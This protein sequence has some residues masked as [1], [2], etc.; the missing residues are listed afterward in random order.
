MA[1]VGRDDNRVTTLAALS[2]SDGTTTVPLW[3]DP[4]THRLLTEFSADLGDLT[5]VTIT[6]AAAG[7]ILY[8]NSANDAWIN[9]A[10]GSN[11]EVLTLASG[12][13]SWAAAGAGDVTAAS[14]FGTDNV[15]I[16]SDGTGK[17][18]QASGISID[19]SDNVTGVNSLVIDST[20]GLDIT[21]GSDTDT[22]LI[23]VNVTG[24]PTLSWDESSDG[25]RING[26]ATGLVLGADGD[27]SH[28]IAGASITSQLE[29]HSDG[30]GELG[31]LA[32]HRHSDTNNF[33][34]HQ[35]FLRSAGSHAS[36]TVVTD[37]MVLGRMIGLGYDG[38]D[39]ET[40]AEIQ[41]LVDGTPG[42]ND[43]PGEI[44]FFTNGGSQALTERMAIRADGTINIAASNDLAWNGTAILSDSAGTMT[45]SNIDALDATTEGTIEA[46]IDTLA[47]LTSAAS[48]ATI[49]TVT[50]GNVDAVVSAASLTAAGKVELATVAETNT[51]TD[52]TRAVTPDGLDGWTGSAQVTTVGTLS[53]GDVDAAVTDASLTAKGKVE[54]AT[55]AETDT[56]TDATR[57]VTPDGLQGSKRNIRYLVF[58]LVADG[59]DVA[60]D[61][62]IGGD[63]T[64][65]FSGTILQ[66]DTDHDQLA[67]TTDTAGTTGTMVVDIH[68][69]GTTIMTTNKL[70]IE[71]TEKG[72]QTATTQPDLTTTDI[73]AGDIL[74]FDVDSIHTTAAKGLKVYMAIRED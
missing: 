67:A 8:R 20:A 21:P 42:N 71:S 18:V 40:A 25:F 31:G 37:N 57:A 62:S 38:T 34:G 45:L 24:T 59:T 36:P 55:I 33:G 63:F 35:L 51:G 13:P 65:P 30:S 56:G 26:G 47:N 1:N 3:A 44:K 29:I 53:S 61:T 58:S 64:V 52:A 28:T 23:T 16:R 7:D 72:T 69:N 68:L 22:D 19:D 15:L 17:G 49:G 14:A 74:T 5:D 11:G 70:D 50:T 32:I 27:L 46:A 60:T 4:T 48:L 54:L 39:Y 41:F 6:S 2:S 10:A 73:S 66:D 43:M 9:L 12:L